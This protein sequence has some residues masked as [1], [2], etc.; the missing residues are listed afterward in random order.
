MQMHE[1]KSISTNFIFNFIKTFAGMIFPIITFSYTSRRL[2]VDGIGRL[3]FSRS[4]ISY[5]SLFA[6]LGIN[7]YGTREAAKIRDNRQKLSKFAHEMLIINGITTILSYFML[8]AS[9]LLSSVL[10]KYALL[11]GITSISIVLTAMGM[12]WLYQGVEEYRY[13]ALRSMAFQLI[14]LVLM[15]FTVKDEKDTAVYAAVS[16]FSSSGSYVLNFINCRKYIDFHYCGRYEIKKHLKPILWLFAFALSVELYT[17]LD[18]TMLGLLKGDQAVGLYSAAIKVNKMV[19]SLIF[20]LGVVLLPRISYYLAQES[21]EKVNKLISQAYNFVF[22]FSIPA[23]IGLYMLSDKII[24]LFSGDGFA[25]SGMTMRLLMPIVLVIPFSALTNNQLF[26]AMNKERKI[27][28]STLT[29]AVVNFTCNMLLIPKWAEN[30]AAVATVLAETA[31]MC[32]CLFHAKKELDIRCVFQNY[33]QYWIAVVPMIGI[34]AVVNCL[35]LFY[36]WKIIL[37]VLMS[38]ICYFGILLCFKNTYLLSIV[39][40]AKRKLYKE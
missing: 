28:S 35:E 22:M 11:L 23:C 34:N 5:F 29:G 10:Q 38:A 7:H 12:E 24:L 20:T 13:I 15:F 18:S 1:K 26:V 39:E 25:S 9:I 36:L 37:V 8:A 6:M 21:R 16:L 32:V 27:L 30:G 14:A 31:V 40:I 19:N 17:V 3:N 2:G 33:Y 4:V